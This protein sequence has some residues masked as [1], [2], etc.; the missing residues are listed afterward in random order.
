MIFLMHGPCIIYGNIQ[1]HGKH[2]KMIIVLFC[3]A[4]CIRTPI[5]IK[6]EPWR[7]K[8]L[9]KNRAS[10]IGSA[11]HAAIQPAEKFMARRMIKAMSFVS[12]LN[13]ANAWASIIAVGHVEKHTR[14][15]IKR[16][17]FSGK[18]TAKNDEKRR[19]SACSAIRADRN[20][21]T[22]RWKSVA[23]A[24]RPHTV[25]WIA[26]RQIGR[27]IGLAVKRPCNELIWLLFEIRNR[28]D[29]R[30]VKIS[31]WRPAR[32][33]RWSWLSRMLRTPYE[34]SLRQ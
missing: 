34:T 26:K 4:V 3:R 24:G 2:C 21:P 14:I 32:F 1:G 31:V 15:L 13:A 20:F 23:G 8:M 18:K 12:Q 28:F 25:V 11:I 22:Q 10:K 5:M 30:L 33:L 17:V 7:V 29:T 27:I 6:M 19:Q 16:N 9:W